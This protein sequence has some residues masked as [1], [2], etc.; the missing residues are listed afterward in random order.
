M[1]T[2]EDDAKIIASTDPLSSAE[3][4]QKVASALSRHFSSKD[5]GE[6]LD[7]LASAD[8]PQIERIESPGSFEHKYRRKYKIKADPFDWTE[9]NNKGK[10]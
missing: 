7:Q 1:F 10:S 4:H 5:I 2:E 6:R 9:L 8:N 3:I